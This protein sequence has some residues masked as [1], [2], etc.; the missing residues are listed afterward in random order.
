VDDLYN[1]KVLGRFAVP[2]LIAETARNDPVSFGRA[3]AKY[4]RGDVDGMERGDVKYVLPPNVRTLRPFRAFSVKVGFPTLT[5]ALNPFPDLSLHWV[6]DGVPITVVV[7][8]ASNHSVH[9]GT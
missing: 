5:I 2:P 9:P 6:T 4:V 8:A 7:S 3:T 1:I